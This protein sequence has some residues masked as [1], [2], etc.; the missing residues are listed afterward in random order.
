MKIHSFTGQMVCRVL[1]IIWSVSLRRFGSLKYNISP[2]NVSW[3]LRRI[4]TMWRLRP[5]FTK[6]LVFSLQNYSTK[7]QS[8]IGQMVGHMLKIIW[9]VSS[10]WVGAL[11]CLKYNISS[12]KRFVVTSSYSDHVT[13]AAHIGYL[14]DSYFR[15]IL[16]RTQCFW[17][18]NLFA[19]LR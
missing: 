8:L 7:I 4:A 9:S 10:R 14:E 11:I 6:I 1:K 2:R 5:V 15:I 16:K 19:F 3:L 13:T 17:V 12:R 18:R